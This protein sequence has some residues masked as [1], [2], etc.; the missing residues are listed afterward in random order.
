MNETGLSPEQLANT[1]G[2]SNMSLRRW[3]EMP[4][5]KRLP[6]ATART[7]IEGVYEL[8][9]EG[10]L[11]SGAPVVQEI[12]EQSPSLSF[13]A[14]LSDMGI[15]AKDLGSGSPYRDNMTVALFQIGSS[16]QRRQ[17]V[18][19]GGD[20]L[21][22]FKKL[23]ADWKAHIT[24]LGKILR[25]KHISHVDKLVAYG[26]LFYLISPV[27]LIPDSIPFAGLLDDYSF[28]ILATA[29]YASRFP[30]LVEKVGDP[31][32]NVPPQLAR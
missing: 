16:A 1:F 5:G 21:K 2:V 8:I 26:A 19:E 32:P 10:K 25:H 4:G 22:W 13:R 12:L 28:L 18:D 23:G 24:S 31:D 20:R 11:Q 27:D 30:H 3:S 9:A 14:V 15:G 17:D 29:Y 6:A 7:V